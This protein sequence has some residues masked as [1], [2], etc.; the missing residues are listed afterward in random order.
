MVK[1]NLTE[2]KLSYEFDNNFNE[3]LDDF[4][5]CHPSFCKSI[6]QESTDKIL[7]VIKESLVESA[8][9]LL[10]D[11]CRTE[12]I[13]VDVEIYAIFEILSGEEPTGISVTKFNLKFT[14]ILIKK[15]E[16]R[17]KFDFPAANIIREN[18][19]NYFAENKGYLGFS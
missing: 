7:N 6:V 14:E 12:S 5:I 15:I 3:T 10:Q 18:A 4:L 17:G 2:L 11:N 19:M 8:E 13:D 1:T 16:E 9:F